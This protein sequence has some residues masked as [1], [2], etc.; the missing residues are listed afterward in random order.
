MSSISS[1]CSTF[2]IFAIS[3]ISS[4]CSVPVPYQQNHRPNAH[5]PTSRRTTRFSNA[6]GRSCSRPVRVRQKAGNP[7][8]PPDAP[9]PCHAV[10]LVG[11]HLTVI[12]N[13][14][15]YQP[16]LIEVYHK[17]LWFNHCFMWLIFLE[18]YFVGYVS[19]S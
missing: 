11:R 4:T 8:K 15:F 17:M 5:R 12:S 9:R 10:S 14:L 3:S 6:V 18:S 16:K 13:Q 2:S 1:T 7:R 19:P